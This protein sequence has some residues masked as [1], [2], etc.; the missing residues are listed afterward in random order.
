MCAYAKI[1]AYFQNGT[2]PGSDN[3]C[4]IEPGPWNITITGGFEKRDDW[5]D[6]QKR[7]KT[8]K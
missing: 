6:L 3:S 5:S 2:M 1:G 4:Q 7:M 8:F